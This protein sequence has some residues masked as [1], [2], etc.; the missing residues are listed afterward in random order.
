MP[1]AKK[2]LILSCS[3]GMGH[4]RAGEALRL[5]CA[6][7][8]PGIQVS[9]IDIAKYFNIF[10]YLYIVFGYN[11]FSKIFPFAYKILYYQTDNAFT[12]KFF[13]LVGP[14]LALSSRRLFAYIKEYQ[15][16]AIISTHFLP[17]IIFPRAFSIPHYT[18]ITDYHAHAVWL[19]TKT[20]GTFVAT[21]E[22]KEHLHKN[23]IESIVSGIPIAPDFFVKKDIAIIKNR[24]G[25]TN[26]WPTILIMPLFTRYKKIEDIIAQIRLLKKEINIFVLPGKNTSLL[27]HI[28]KLEKYNVLTPTAHTPIDEL[29]RCAD[30]II[31]KA[32]GL[33]ISEVICLQKPLIIADSVPG[34]EEDNTVYLEKNGYALH[35]TS[36][37]DVTKKI[38][39]ILNNPSCIQKKSYPESGKIIL[40]S[41]FKN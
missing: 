12:K 35:A 38:Q 31:S 11:F 17:H 32:G 1:Q 2:L 4:W 16:D 8:Y 19:S 18:V 40:D 23:N 15:P 9:H 10:A 27:K 33:T 29:M 24:L 30:I 7:L 20:S 22:I 14:A 36:A 37:I 21:E 26:N 41:I 3:T 28:G 39:M 13:G 5:H 25:I 6:N 34:Q